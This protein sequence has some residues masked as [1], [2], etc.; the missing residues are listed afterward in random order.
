M[1][2]KDFKEQV[3]K[4]VEEMGYELREL[5]AEEQEQYKPFI[6]LQERLRLYQEQ[7]VADY[8]ATPQVIRLNYMEHIRLKCKEIN[9]AEGFKQLL[10]DE[11]AMM[12]NKVE[13]FTHIERIE[14][15]TLNKLYK[16]VIEKELD[17]TKKVDLSDN[18]KFEIDNQEVQVEGIKF[19]E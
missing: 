16:A 9:S 12:K 6:E 11:R 14:Y 1:E 17:I 10:E 4:Y 13:P 18:I 8:F 19:K 2:Q 3:E 5:T 15:R 7:V